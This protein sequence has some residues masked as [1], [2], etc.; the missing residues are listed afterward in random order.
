M[1][2]GSIK[3]QNRQ[4]RDKDIIDNLTAKS[5]VSLF[6]SRKLVHVIHN[7]PRIHGQLT[8]LLLFDRLIPLEQNLTGI[9]RSC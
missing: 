5:I 4:R 2:E 8:H 6:V 3:E 1:K 9:E 7:Y